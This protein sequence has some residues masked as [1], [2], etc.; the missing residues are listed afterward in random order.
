MA[1]GLTLIVDYGLCNT[2][3]MLRALEE[4]GA[5]RVGRSCDPRQVAKADRLVLPGV[6]TFF[7]AMRNIREWGLLDEIRAQSE[8]GTPFLGACLGMQ[9]MASSG[10][11]GSR[12]GPIEGLGL[13]SGTVVRLNPQNADERIPH[14]GWNEVVANGS[15]LFNGLPEKPDFYFVHSYHVRLDCSSEEAG[16]SDYCGGF[17]AAIQADGKP[18]FGVQ[19]HPEKSQKN[20]FKLLKNFLAT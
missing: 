10:S 13:I 2:D 19:F 7:A 20:G 15:S 12:N 11:E 3:S 8:R 6:G 16:R 1:G 18:I 4:C 14:V 17:T 9:L 5:D